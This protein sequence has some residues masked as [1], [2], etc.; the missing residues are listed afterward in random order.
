MDRIKGLDFFMFLDLTKAL[1]EKGPFFVVSFDFC[2]GDFW[3][4]LTSV[5]WREVLSVSIF[6]LI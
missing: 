4:F 5:G 6:L 2:N 3:T 1:A